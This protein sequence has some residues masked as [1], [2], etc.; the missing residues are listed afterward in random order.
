[1]SIPS[2]I[3]SILFVST[4]PLSLE[5]IA[6]ICAVKKDEAQKALEELEAKYQSEDSGIK[7]MRDGR[8]YQMVSDAKNSPVVRE[9]LKDERT[10]ELTRPA[11]ETLTIIAYRGPITKGELELIRGVNCSLII[12]N[13]L[14]KGLIEAEEDKKELVTFYRVTF[15][16]LRFLGINKQEEL[17][18][19]EKL[20]R[21]KRLED[22]I[23]S[24]EER[25]KT[26]PA[27]PL[28]HIEPHEA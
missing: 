28:P 16:F 8:K 17:P 27:S 13:L 21:D 6:L 12:R 9:F 4:K 1:M 19:F 10:G 22:L 26:E 3:E 11:L 24:E 23:V 7:L 14:I 5:K 20:C 25:Q 2:K 18:D 15:D